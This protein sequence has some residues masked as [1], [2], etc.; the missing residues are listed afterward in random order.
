[1]E[2][3]KTGSMRIETVTRSKVDPLDAYRNDTKE[4]ALR[5]VAEI[6]KTMKTNG[7]ATD[8]IKEFFIILYNSELL[9]T[10]KVEKDPVMYRKYLDLTREEGRTMFDIDTGEPLKFTSS[11]WT[12]KEGRLDVNMPSILGMATGHLD[13]ERRAK[14][15]DF[16]YVGAKAA[17]PKKVSPIKDLT[18]NIVHSRGSYH[19][20]SLFKEFLHTG[21]LTPIHHKYWSAKTGMVEAPDGIVLAEDNDVVHSEHHR[22]HHHVHNQGR[23][24]SA[25]PVG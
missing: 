8:Y 15:G 9:P 6:Y 25:I 1:M 5:R 13:I 23:V 4:T 12:S 3:P 18:Q 24:D 21:P 20:H 22:H 2:K 11:V 14:D 19:K 16:I 17:T 7:H 10:D